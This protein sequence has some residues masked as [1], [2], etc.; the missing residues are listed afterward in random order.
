VF[1]VTVV[2]TGTYLCML[3][4]IT[5][6]PSISEYNRFFREG[7]SFQQSLQNS[8]PVVIL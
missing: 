1:N 4:E 6:M 2:H 5:V 7:L 8:I 3:V